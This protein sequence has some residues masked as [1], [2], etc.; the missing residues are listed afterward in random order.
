[1]SD[2]EETR[3]EVEMEVNEEEFQNWFDEEWEKQQKESKE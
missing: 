3:I 1:M 2:E